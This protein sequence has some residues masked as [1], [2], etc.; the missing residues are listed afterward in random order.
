MGIGW[1]FGFIASA[2]DVQ[3]LWWIFIIINSLHGPL[4][5]ASV[6]FSSHFKEEVLKKSKPTTSR[7]VDHGEGQGEITQPD[8]Q[9]DGRKLDGH[10]RSG[11]S[12]DVIQTTTM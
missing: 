3:I 10:S 2:S 5:L 7:P 11:E 9:S 4:L 8:N 12:D 6:L 1:I